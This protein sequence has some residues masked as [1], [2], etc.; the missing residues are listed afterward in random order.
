M[1]RVT[2]WPY[3]NMREAFRNRAGSFGLVNGR[4][5]QETYRGLP[6]VLFTAGNNARNYFASYSVLLG[7]NVEVTAS[8]G[9]SQEQSKRHARAVVQALPL[10]EIVAWKRAD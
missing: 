10:N 7:D 1:V 9:G 8:S 2:Q 4:H 5:T 6:A 3:P